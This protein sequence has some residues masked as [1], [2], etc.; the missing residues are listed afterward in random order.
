[1]SEIFSNKRDAESILKLIV[2]S[3]EDVDITR[4][5]VTADSF[6]NFVYFSSEEELSEHSVIYHFDMNSLQRNMIRKN[7]VCKVVWAIW[8]KQLFESKEASGEFLMPA[9]EH[10][11]L[12]D[13]GSARNSLGNQNVYII[14][15]AFEMYHGSVHQVTPEFLWNHLDF[16]NQFDRHTSLDGESLSA[17]IEKGLFLD[18]ISQDKSLKGKEYVG[19]LISFT[20]YSYDSEAAVSRLKS[21]I[22][23]VE[24]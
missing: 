10:T 17:W 2:H 7:L 3:K 9:Y 1:M 6:L 5:G 23:N 13:L 14:Q 4:C 24:T 11:F 16:L 21:I 12:I 18:Q 8:E 20:G 15:S 19:Q 22:S